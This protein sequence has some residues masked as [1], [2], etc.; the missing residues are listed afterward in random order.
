[1]RYAALLMTACALAACSKQVN[2]K[3]A[4]VAQVAKA[5]QESGVANDSFLQAGQWQVKG[6][7]ED[8][9]GPGMPPEAKAQ[10]KKFMSA[11]QD[12]PVKYCVTPEEAKRPAA[13]MFAGKQAE[14]CRYDHFTM[15]GGKFDVAMQCQAPKGEAAGG[16]MSMQASG[17]YA[18]DHYESHTV[19]TVQGGPRGSMTMKSSSEAQ[20]IGECTAEQ[21][22]EKKKDQQG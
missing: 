3:N 5:V 6:T 15:G 8:I 22:A 4:S 1:M 14:N 21:L 20:R 9:D 12:E 7:L 18:P 11:M 10:M 13:Q 19:M 16:S 2:E 17:T